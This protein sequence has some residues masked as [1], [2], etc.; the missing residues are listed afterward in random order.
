MSSPQ[1]VS[2]SQAKEWLPGVLCLSENDSAFPWQEDLLSRLSRG[3]VDGLVDIPTGLG[4]TAVMAIWLLARACGAALPRRLVYVVD[5][6]AVVDQATE[7]AI[8]IREYVGRTPDL[9][10]ALGLGDRPLPI[11]TL[12]GRHVDNREWLEDPASPAIIVGTIDMIGS[13]LLFE[14]YGVSRRMRPYHAGLLG[15]DAIVVLDEAHLVPP[16]ESLVDAIANGS[17]QFGAREEPAIEVLPPLKLMSL[18]ATSRESSAKPFSL[19]DA[20]EHHSAVKKRLDAP[21]R[22]TLVDLG[23]DREL[24]EALARHAWEL[25]DR[26]KKPIRCVVFCDKREDAVKAK[27]AIEE[28]TRDGAS[29]ELL[30]GG[31]RVFERQNAAKRLKELGFL[32]GADIPREN[33]AF[34]FATSAGEVGIDLD[35]DHM[36]SDLVAWERMVQRLGRVNRRGEGN[37]DVTVVIDADPKRTDQ[38]REMLEA[39]QRS[40]RSFAFG[41]ASPRAIRDLKHKAEVDSDLRNT[42]RAATTPPPL[43]PA[44]TRAV[45]DA[46]SMTSLK[47]HTG[48][49]H[50]G[51]WLRGWLPEDAQTTVV[52]RTNL[53]AREGATRDL[54]EFFEAAP[55]HMSEM[56]ET[57]THRVV[58]W[59]NARGKALLGNTGNAPPSEG[60]MAAI[61]LSDAGDLREVLSFDHLANAKQKQIP[62]GACV[63]VDAR[64][65]GLKEGLLDDKADDLPR[66]VDDGEEWLPDVDGAPVIRFRV[67]DDSASPPNLPWRE[68]FRLAA[69]G[70]NEGQEIRA[71]VVYKWR[72]DGAIE[73]DRS[74]GPPQLLDVHQEWAARRARDLAARLTLL[75]PYVEMLA[76]AAR[77]HDEGKRA[78]RWQHAARAP[79]D[80]IYGKTSGPMNPALLDGYR[81]ELGSFLIAKDHSLLASLS[82][83]LRDLALHLITAHHGS[84]RPTICLDGCDKGPPSVLEEEAREIAL[85]F[86]RLQK[87]WGPWG[88]AWWEAL[89]RAAD[90]Q[91]SRE[92]GEQGVPIGKAN[93]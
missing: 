7:V 86:A 19:T 6:R 35:A 30:L 2:F 9:R 82:P 39:C 53:P 31:R 88:L 12:R 65:A 24:P 75:G 62:P 5:R 69:D 29:T 34:L 83:D 91:S 42:L 67:M 79:D 71:L 61:V 20:D 44:L 80:A 43:R 11:S 27:R 15:T 74:T 22:L 14:G 59:L 77:L 23:H 21:K 51:P 46:W 90:Q 84:G 66:T 92:N 37:A 8:Q 78:A 1:H 87:R 48:R 72:H 25:A 32:A 49:P 36:V 68:R 63:I 57:E 58:R 47:E 52:W 76:V 56:L 33:P 18:S 93:C 10:L 26:G 50:V 54:E 41:D 13:R 40:L 85:R 60:E 81:H 16:F 38:E 73:D 55:P 3:Q 17:A 64:V 89:L 45:V 70:T 28:L 4:K